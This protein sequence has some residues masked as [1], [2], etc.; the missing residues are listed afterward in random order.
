MLCY[1]GT[2]IDNLPSILANG[3][4]VNKDKVWTCSEEAIYCYSKNMFNDLLDN[5]GADV[6]MDNVTIEDFHDYFM[7]AAFD[8]ASCT[9]PKSKQ[10]V[11]VVVVFDVPEDE[12]IDDK[13]C[14]FMDEA[15][16]VYRDIQP[17]EIKAIYISNDLTMLKGYYMAL[18]FERPLYNFWPTAFEREIIKVFKNAEIYPE[19]IEDMLEWEEYPLLANS[20]V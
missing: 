15:N 3:L 2:N 5:S 16:C 8:S 11:A 1:H 14:P 7:R 19:N 10:C 20:N 13:S 12:I 18:M 17:E 6:D 4:K 9:F